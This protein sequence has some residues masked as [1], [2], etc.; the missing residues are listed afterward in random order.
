MCSRT[1]AE[2]RPVTARLL[3]QLRLDLR[4]AA[5]SL[6]RNPGFTA[7]AVLCLALG[8]GANATTF[9]VV[10]ALLFR[11]PPHVRDVE[12]VVRIYFGSRSK[13]PGQSSTTNLPNYT[14][15]AGASGAFSDVAAYYTTHTSLGRGSEAQQV[16]ASLVS[17]SFFRLLDVRPA[18]GRFFTAGEDSSGAA[19]VA[20]LGY[21]LWK[22]AFAGSRS[23][24]GRTLWIG[25]GFYTVVGVAPDWFTGADLAPVD[26]W[27]PIQTAAEELMGRGVLR[28]RG[29]FWVNVLA[30]LAKGVTPERGAS[31]ANLFLK[32]G[33]AADPDGDTTTTASLF[34]VLRDRGPQRSE[35]AQTSLWVAAAAGAV[36]LIACANLAGLL[37][38]RSMA[39]RRETAV[40]LALGAGRARLAE[41]A[42]VES[43]L[44]ATGAAAVGVLLALWG[45]A[46]LRTFLLPQVGPLR[47][48]FNVHVLAFTG[49]VAVAGALLCGVIPALHASRSDPS[50]GLRSA[51]QDRI[52]TSSR[53]QSSLI[54]SQAALALVLVVGTG[55]FVRSLSNLKARAGSF[56]VNRLLMVTADL[57]AAGYGGPDS[58]VLL[59]RM[60]ARLL[61]LHGVVGASLA[62]GM[63]FR[64]G[65]AVMV[66]L[67]GS[68]GRLPMVPYIYPVGADWF[69]TAGTTILQGRA[70][71]DADR[72]GAPRVVIVNATMARAFW[73]GESPLGKC[74]LLGDVTAPRSAP[75]PCGEVVGIAADVARMFL[76]DSADAMY[77][78][79][80]E[81]NATPWPAKYLLVRTASGPAATIPAVRR[82]L[83]DVAPDLPF[84]TV[85]PAEDMFGWQ[86]QPWRMGTAMFGVFA[87]L[88]L[89]LAAVG[90]YGLL[91][92]V[93]T[94]RTPELAVRMALGAEASEVRWLVV[95]HGLKLASLGVVIGVP[96][97]MGLGRALAS[98]LFGVSA[99]N[100]ML[101]TV[102]AAVLLAVAAAAS[103]VPARRA[104][105]LDP[106]LALRA[107]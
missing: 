2:V 42:L 4:Y 58:K 100:P 83:Q 78:V 13:G 47:A 95:R 66:G 85:Q 60:R 35:G 77:F 37:L 25:G 68:S 98:R 27:L 33:N 76:K 7:V 80:I 29:A 1:K 32:R 82:A 5:R 12:R 39:R 19:R 56:E 101:L 97:A 75:M 10:D 51:G 43:G 62:V 20:V 99:S 86:L 21:G 63:P 55:L 61:R 105:R 22:R 53:W 103:Y 30:R 14:D 96:F 107:E 67:P 49:G 69:K 38:A 11:A 41:Q 81:Q 87:L 104:T 34:P 31:L 93:V 65:G 74:L 48:V 92:F 18:I 54:V 15:I 50:T 72:A 71:T 17:A 70:F 79:P 46:A 8:I 26:V 6:G 16:S 44:L 36:L 24:L 28:S 64:E 84:V 3:D 89:L 106:A 94:R 73:P 40:R 59:E 45:G 57:S 52:V 91:S 9:G 90:L 23:V 102:G 88:G